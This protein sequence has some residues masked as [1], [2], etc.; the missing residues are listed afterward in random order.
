[1]NRLKGIIYD[2]IG[3]LATNWLPEKVCCKKILIVRADEIGD[4]MLWHVFIEDIVTA[5][6]FRDYEFHFCGNQSTK[7]LFNTFDTQWIGHTYW[8]DK[9]RFKKKFYT[10]TVSEKYLSATFR[11]GYQPNFFGD[12]RYD[13]SIVKAAKAPETLGMRANLESIKS[14]EEGYDKGLYTTVI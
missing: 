11:G 8:M 1:M 4:F 7:S 9:I 2:C 5:E 14:Y 6:K 3:W 12:K 13:D 10:V